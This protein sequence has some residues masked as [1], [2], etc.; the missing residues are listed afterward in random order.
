MINTSNH[1]PAAA[2]GTPAV[3]TRRYPRRFLIALMSIPVMVI[4]QFAMLAIIPVVLVLVWALRDTRLRALRSWSIALGVVYATPLVIWLVRPDGAQSLS[5][6]MN[7]V[8]VA[9]ITVAAAAVLLRMYT[10]KS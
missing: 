8:F 6:D 10:R 4:G 2:A 1:A 5:K 7:P 3:L 9:L